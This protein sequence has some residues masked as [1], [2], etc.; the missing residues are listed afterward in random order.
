MGVK[1]ILCDARASYA[2]AIL[3]LSSDIMFC[4][5]SELAGRSLTLLNNFVCLFEAHDHVIS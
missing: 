2:R 3:R 1:I 4:L 5:G